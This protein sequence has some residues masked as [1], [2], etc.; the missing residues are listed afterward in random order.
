M[1]RKLFEKFTPDPKEEARERENRIRI[2]A[3]VILLEVAKS[4]YEFSSL[5]RDVV[6]AILEEEF[7]IPQ[8]AVSELIAIAESERRENVDLYEFTRLIK[9]SL[10][11]EERNRLI[12]FA[13]EIVY[14]DDKLDKFEDH[15]IHR[16]SILLGLDHHELIE[17]KMRV[18]HED[19]N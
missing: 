7:G 4:D 2:A 17:A 16:L 14:A 18:L 12:E 5:E 6:E 13:W 1:I 11:R 19:E 9:E 3:C 8:E 10:S 15:L